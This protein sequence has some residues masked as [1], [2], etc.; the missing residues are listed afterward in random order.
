MN[1]KR[2]DLPV[3]IDLFAGAG[4]LSEGL[5]A[6]GVNVA[7]AL[8]KHPHPALTYAFNHPGTSVLCGQ[9]R[10]ANLDR[11]AEL[12]HEKTGQKRVDVIA[13]GPPCQGYSPAG[14]RRKNDRRNNLYA[15]FLRFVDYF[16]PRM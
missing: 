12:I 9:I 7:V 2:R 15:E 11:I 10:N 5:M 3:A 13:G 8:E 6:A 16:Q 14:K 4:G 1:A